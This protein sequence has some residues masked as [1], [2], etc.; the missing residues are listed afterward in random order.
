MVR[1]LQSCIG[2]DLSAGDFTYITLKLMSSCSFY[3]FL[4][5]HEKYFKLDK[6]FAHLKYEKF[7]YF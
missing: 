2:P 3:G 4:S 6:D 7:H 5:K 1:N